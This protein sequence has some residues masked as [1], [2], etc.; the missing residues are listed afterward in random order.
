M[1]AV[2]E[3]LTPDNI[4]PAENAGIVQIFVNLLEKS[5]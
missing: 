4:I 3:V 5:L 1:S 2:A